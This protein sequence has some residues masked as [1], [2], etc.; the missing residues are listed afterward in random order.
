MYKGINEFKKGNKPEMKKDC[1]IIV[2]DTTMILGWWEQFYSNLLTVPQCSKPEGGGS[3]IF[4]AESDIPDPSLLVVE[5]AT[6]NFKTIK[7]PQ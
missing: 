4:T 1:G 5:F 6:D 2:A 7:F 3:D